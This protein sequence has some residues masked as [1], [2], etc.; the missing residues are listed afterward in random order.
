MTFNP[1]IYLISFH[2]NKFYLFIELPFLFIEFSL[3]SDLNQLD[4]SC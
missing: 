1:T 3:E 2:F 4:N